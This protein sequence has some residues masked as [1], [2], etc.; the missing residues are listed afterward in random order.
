MRPSLKSS[1]GCSFNITGHSPSSSR[2]AS[3]LIYS[4]PEPGKPTQVMAPGATL[5]YVVLQRRPDFRIWRRDILE[6]RGHDAD[7]RIE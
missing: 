5:R 6:S 1:L 4:C 3:L 2:D 7:D